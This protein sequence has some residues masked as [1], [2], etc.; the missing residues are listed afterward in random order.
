MSAKCIIDNLNYMREYIGNEESFVVPE[1]IV[2]IYCTAFCKSK[3]LKQVILPTSA[4]YCVGK[5]SCFVSD[6]IEYVIIQ[7]ANFSGSF[8]KKDMPSLKRVDVLD[9]DPTHI[10]NAGRL[11]S[12]LTNSNIDCIYFPNINLYACNKSDLSDIKMCIHFLRHKEIY[13]NME[14]YKYLTYI[15]KHASKIVKLLIDEKDFK[16]LRTL[17][18]ICD[19]RVIKANLEHIQQ[20]GNTE[21]TAI[22]IDKSCSEGQDMTKQSFDILSLTDFSDIFDDTK[23]INIAPSLTDRELKI[24]LEK[25]AGFEV[26]GIEDNTIILGAA[27]GNRTGIIYPSKIREYEVEGIGMPTKIPSAEVFIVAITNGVSA[28]YQN[29]FIVYRSLAMVYIPRSVQ[30]IDANAFLYDLHKDT[31]IFCEHDTYAESWA[32]KNGYK[33]KNSKYLLEE[34]DRYVARKEGSL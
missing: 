28:I 18:D 22:A 4:I 13:T 33:S 17:I 7:N 23:S 20:A 14:Q 24:S 6:S 5:N 15:N 8:N 32:A 2:G 16:A 19:A 1:G 3:V 27:L 11:V 26:R 34:L 29:A 30:Y 10:A 12:S 25:M 31:L 9:T 21:I